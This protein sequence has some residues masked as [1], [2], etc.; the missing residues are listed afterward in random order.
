[1]ETPSVLK[2]LIMLFFDTWF[3]RTLENLENLEMEK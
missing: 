1:M 3:P 2:I